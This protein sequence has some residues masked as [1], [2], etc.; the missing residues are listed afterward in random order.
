MEGHLTKAGFIMSGL[1]PN[2]KTPKSVE[3]PE[4]GYLKNESKVGNQPRVQKTYPTPL[5]PPPR[6]GWQPTDWAD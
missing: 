6:R 3:Q 2:M 4:G 1:D 5:D